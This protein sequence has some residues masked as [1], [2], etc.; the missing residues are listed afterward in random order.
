MPQLKT[1]IPVPF[2]VS[3]Y[4]SGSSNGFERVL[5][6]S[7]A[8]DTMSD[9]FP[10]N[11]LRDNCNILE[12]VL[13][14]PVFEPNNINQPYIQTLSVLQTSLAKQIQS[15]FDISDQMVVI[16]GDHS[17]A[18]GT[19]LGLSKCVDMSKVALIWVDAHG[20]CNTPE[21]SLSKCIT[22][23]PAAVNTGLGLKQLTEPF[24]GNFIQKLYYIG[25]RDVDE[26]EIDNLNQV[27]TKVYSSLDVVELGIAKIMDNILQSLVG[28]EYIW[29]SID[30]DSLDPVYFD[31]RETDVPVVGGLTPREL[32]YITKRC[33]S[34]GLL[35]LTELVQINDVGHQTDIT[36]LASRI[37]EMALNLGNFR[38]AK[39]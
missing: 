35:K 11:L 14:D 2:A 29:L 30:I 31:P 20:D 9:K 16:G 3:Q 10:S 33:Q 19:G 7:A 6:V 23:Y 1:I 27:S 38:I 37:V 4:G 21:T 32:L 36:V 39:K 26:L 34:S 24:G 18:V 15:I 13:I 5:N 12:P 28:V 22:G 17:I 25:L 8:N